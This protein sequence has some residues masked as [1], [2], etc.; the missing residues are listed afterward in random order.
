MIDIN[1]LKNSLND[2]IIIVNFMTKKNKPYSMRCTKNY[3]HIP[4]EKHSGA[5]SPTLI[6]DN[7]VA[8]FDLDQNEWRC[9]RKDKITSYK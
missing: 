7:I 9:F 4:V 8:A 3:H 2:G 6:G 1:A 5:N